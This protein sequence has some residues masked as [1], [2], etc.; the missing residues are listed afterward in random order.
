MEPK[1]DKIAG[2][3]TATKGSKRSGVARRTEILTLDGCIPV[4]FLN[5]GDRVVTRD[6]G[7]C[8]LRDIS[9]HFGLTA[10]YRIGAGTMA[11]KRPTR[12]LMVASGQHVLIRDWRARILFDKQ[13]ALVPVSRLSDGT[14]ISAEPSA[15]GDRF[16][17]LH[18]DVNCVIYANGVELASAAPVRVKA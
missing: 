16:F 18:F 15:I 12:D 9:I 7:I 4:E 17:G 10:P 8:V 6:H 14:Y 5:S 13:Q 1:Q 3:A 2:K 11:G